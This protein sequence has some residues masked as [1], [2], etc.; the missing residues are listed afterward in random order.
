MARIVCEAKVDGKGRRILGIVVSTENGLLHVC[1]FC[2][3]EFPSANIFES[4]EM[5]CAQT[6]NIN[7]S[8]KHDEHRSSNTMNTPK[9]P[10]PAVPSNHAPKNSANY[11]SLC[12][13]EYTCRRSLQRHYFSRT[14]RALA[15][16]AEVAPQRVVK[17][18]K[19]LHAAAGPAFTIKAELLAPV[20]KS[21]M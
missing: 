1:N 7:V 21:K 14:H 17:R 5:L 4:H 3:K 13:R 12:K 8:Q 11:C 16:T 10:T 6:A 9:K 15:Q 18:R 20:K 19:T 2:D